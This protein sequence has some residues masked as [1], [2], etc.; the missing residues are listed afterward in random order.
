[1]SPHWAGDSEHLPGHSRDGA[2]RPDGRGPVDIE[3]RGVTGF[4]G[5]ISRRA[6]VHSAI[7]DSNI[8]DIDVADHIAVRRHVLPD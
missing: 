5:R 6:F 1:M 4:S 8:G 2:H 7:R 3:T